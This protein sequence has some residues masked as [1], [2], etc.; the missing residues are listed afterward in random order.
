M[1]GITSYILDNLVQDYFIHLALLLRSS[2]KMKNGALVVVMVWF[3]S[4]DVS[5]CSCKCGLRDSQDVAPAL[6]CL[7]GQDEDIRVARPIK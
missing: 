4:I 1:Y 3:T 5:H 6:D 2:S 7:L